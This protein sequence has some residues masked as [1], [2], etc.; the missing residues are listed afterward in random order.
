LTRCSASIGDGLPPNILMDSLHKEPPESD[1]NGPC[2]TRSLHHIQVTA[3]TKL[4]E[5]LAVKSDADGNLE[6]FISIFDLQA[7]SLLP[8]ISYDSSRHDSLQ[9]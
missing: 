1:T 2:V 6:S 7:R 9:L 5:S 3:M 8:H 4:A